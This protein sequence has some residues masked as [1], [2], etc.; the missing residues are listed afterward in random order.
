M[1]AFKDRNGRQWL[2]DINVGAIK[3]VRSE[4]KINLC[5]LIDDGFKGLNEL[6]SDPIQLV[7]VV[8]VLCQEQAK[9][10]GILDTQFGE[11]LSGESLQSMADAFFEAY[12]DFSPDRSRA[13]L[14]SIATKA[15]QL[16]EKC[17][18]MLEKD[19]ASLDV[20]LLVEN[21]RKKSGS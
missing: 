4:L 13:A 20:D 14:R 5:S 9:S 1:S 18:A 3:R 10:A 19:L 16:T 7:D 15:K 11:S 21:L 6:M 8:F 12:V 17:G 2:I